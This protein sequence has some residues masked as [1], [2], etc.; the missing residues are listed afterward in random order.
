MKKATVAYLFASVMGITS[1][2]AL[3][4]RETTINPPSSVVSIEE[5]IERAYSEIARLLKEKEEIVQV[6]DYKPSN[7]NTLEELAIIAEELTEDVAMLAEAEGEIIIHDIEEVFNEDVSVEE[8]P[9]S[10]ISFQDVDSDLMRA[11]VNGELL[12]DYYI[13]CEKGSVLPFTFLLKGDFVS[14]V[15]NQ[16]MDLSIVLLKSFY[17]SFQAGEI[18]LSEDG[19]NWSHFDDFFSGMIG[20]AIGIENGIPQASLQIEINRQ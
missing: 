6:A 8:P 4:E 3:E 20:A 2:F 11:F 15:E 13:L 9:F 16:K 19:E 1:I 7:H 12:P 14:M 18:R 10:F 5:A 17:L